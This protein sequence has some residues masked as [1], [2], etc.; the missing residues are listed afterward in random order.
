MILV[1]SNRWAP[2]YTGVGQRIQNLYHLLDVE[3]V[4]ISGY[5]QTKKTIVDTKCLYVK[6]YYLEFTII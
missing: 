3:Y 2:E 4:V 1:I 6:K 5:H